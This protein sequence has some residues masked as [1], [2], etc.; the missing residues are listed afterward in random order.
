MDRLTCTVILV[1]CAAPA[2]AQMPPSSGVRY[3]RLVIQNAMVI[4][5]AGNPARGPYDIVVEGSRIVRVMRHRRG[6]TPGFTTGSAYNLR[7]DLLTTCDRIR[8]QPDLFTTGSTHNR[9]Y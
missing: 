7:P 8:L 9:I 5:G 1:L 4:D 3:D 2:V 6:R